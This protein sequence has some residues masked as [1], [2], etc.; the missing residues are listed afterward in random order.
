MSTPAPYM[1]LQSKWLR[2]RGRNCRFLRTRKLFWKGRFLRPM[3]NRLPRVLSENGP[4]IIRTRAKNASFALSRS[5]IGI[6]LLCL[7]I[8]RCALYFHGVAI[9]QWP[10]LKYGIILS[11]RESPTSQESGDI[12]VD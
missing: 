5:L 8:R 10:A 12:V 2:D 9:C 7:V 1:A 4:V 3:K 11:D 6:P